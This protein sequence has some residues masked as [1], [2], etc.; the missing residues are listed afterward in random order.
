MQALCRRVAVCACVRVAELQ[1]GSVCVRA[2]MQGGGQADV[3]PCVRA[4]ARACVCVCHSVRHYACGMVVW[5]S[6]AVV[7]CVAECVCVFS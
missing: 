6:A 5:Q 4:R 3:R 1:Y 7:Q 2:C